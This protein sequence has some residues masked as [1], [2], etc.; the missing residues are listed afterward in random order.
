MS[1]TELQLESLKTHVGRR[2]QSADVV[3]AAPANILRLTFGRP[4][5]EYGPGDALPPGWHLLYFLPRFRADELR[6]D[7]SPRDAGV[8][9]PMPLP[10]RMFAG[11]HVRFHRPLRIG[12][13]L[14][15]ETELTDIAVKRGGTGGT[16][17]VSRG[18]PSGRSAS[19]A[20]RG[21]K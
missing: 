21:R 4:E 5:P 18:L 2:Q 6:P 12:Q 11:E 15:R 1:T 10:R 3:T 17:P 7:G 16:T 20:T 14:T 19:A 9:P 8:V 13:A